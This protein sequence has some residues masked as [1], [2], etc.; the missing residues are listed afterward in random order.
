M[1]F[2]TVRRMLAGQMKSIDAHEA[3]KPYVRQAMV[4]D[5]G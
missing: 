1:T 2:M 3:L 5:I 4:I